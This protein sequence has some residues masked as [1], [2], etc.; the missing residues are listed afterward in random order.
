[1]NG[2]ASAVDVVTL[3]YPGFPTDFL[4]MIV[5]LNSVADGAA[6]VTENVFEGRFRANDV[7]IFSDRPFERSTARKPKPP[8]F[9]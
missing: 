7:V 4:P 2:R 9:V 6:M 1:M 8:A 5:A 3:P